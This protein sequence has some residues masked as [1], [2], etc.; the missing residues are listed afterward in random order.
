MKRICLFSKV[1]MLLMCLSAMI[2]SEIAAQVHS[3]AHIGFVYPLSTNGHKAAE[4]SNNL[5]LHAIQGLSGGEK[6]LALYG[7]AG[8]V[9]GDVS[10]LQAAGVFNQVSG[11]L[12]GVQMAGVMNQANQAP[13]GLQFAG[14]VNLNK[15]TS[16]LQMAGV[17]NM[18]SQISSFQNAG[19]VNLAQSLE[20]IQMA[21][22]A[23]AAK[24]VKGIQ[25]AGVVNAANEVKGSQFAGLINIAKKVNGVQVAGLLNIADSSDY[26][27][28][29]I[30][31]I[32]TGEKR[33]GLATDENLSTIV[34]FRSGGRKLYGIIGMGSNLQ[35]ADLPYGVE[36]GLGIKLIEK[37]SFRMDMEAVNLFITDFKHSEYSKSGLRILPSFLLSKNLQLYAGPS[38]NYMDT[39]NQEGSDLAGLRIWER[40]RTSTY[41]SVHVGYTVGLQVLL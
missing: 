35:Y 32:K 3:P 14:V 41:R 18:A 16:P 17:V 22:V 23:N 7:V 1:A 21:G 20:G 8:M 5:S 31:L 2:L 19:V 40:Q 27:I 25:V 26:P 39:K 37:N 29:I 13:N 11:E 24:C 12:K 38:I 28:G 30:N 4:Y 9:K 34:S 15:G 33:I 10:G 6:G 36:A